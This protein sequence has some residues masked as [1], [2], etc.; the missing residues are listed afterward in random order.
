MSGF[1][2]IAIAT[3]RS[4]VAREDYSPNDVEQEF[5]EFRNAKQH[6][7]NRKDTRFGGYTSASTSR[8]LRGQEAGAEEE[9]APVRAHERA[10]D[11]D[12]APFSTRA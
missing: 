2:C 5:S 3:N 9:D 7:S 1:C 6:S 4:V 11:C 8:T 12:P 10:H